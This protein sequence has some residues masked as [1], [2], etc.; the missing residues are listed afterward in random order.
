MAR[1]LTYIS[2]VCLD[3]GR[4]EVVV[5][6]LHPFL[7]FF[8]LESA[9][10]GGECHDLFRGIEILLPPVHL[11]LIS[12]ESARM[13]FQL[14]HIDR[15]LACDPVHVFLFKPLLERCGC[16]IANCMEDTA[17]QLSFRVAF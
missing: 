13:L 6:Y 7:I 16:T 14:K 8:S 1:C 9:N 11:T 10:F 15:Y 5:W 4:W 17:S 12:K 2:H 3:A